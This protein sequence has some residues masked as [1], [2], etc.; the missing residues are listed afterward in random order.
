[1]CLRV[2]F[3]FEQAWNVTVDW[4]KSLLAEMRSVTDR[5]WV[6]MGPGDWTHPDSSGCRGTICTSVL[7]F[8]GMK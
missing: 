1:M 7:A 6:R 5:V 4:M 3:P 2:C 8:V